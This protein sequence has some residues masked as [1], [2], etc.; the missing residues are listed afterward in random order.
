MELIEWSQAFEL[1][2]QT[3]D[4]QHRRL[5]DL[6]NSFG[7]LLSDNE[8]DSEALEKVFFDL[9]EYTEYHFREEEEL[10]A[11]MGVDERHVEPHQ[12]QHRTFLTD[13]EVLYREMPHDADNAGTL[14]EYLMS[15]LVY[16]ILGSDRCLGRQIALICDEVSPQEAYARQEQTADDAAGMLLS[17]LNKLFHQV[18]LRNRQLGELNQSLEQKVADRT[19]ELSNANQR[20]DELAS[21]DVLTGLF[22]RRHA[23]QQLQQLWDETKGSG[24]F[25]CM[26]IDADGFKQ[27][28][29]H[30]GHDAGD[31]VLRELARWLKHMVRTDDVVCRLGGDEFLILCPG[32]DAAGVLQVA[33]QVH[34]GVATLRVDFA[35]GAW[36]G[37]ISI[38]V[39]TR[40]KE[41]HKPEDLIKQ[42]DRAVYVAKEA[43][44]NCVR[45]AP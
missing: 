19:S 3:I 20:L 27:I 21:T 5:V 33:R 31:Q 10:M 38:G 6:T 29:D 16:H 37:S 17:S 18:S 12:Q 34:A 23:L 24:V 41:M 44:K 39:A 8:I 2:L 26:M 42:A 36:E 9:L 25:S 35:G 11:T 28:N 4:E 30:Y 45:E 1:G 14:F 15:W 7:Q 40:T 43:G 32:T 13:V 22:N